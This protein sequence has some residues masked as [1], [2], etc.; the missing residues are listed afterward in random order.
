MI[1]RPYEIFNEVTDVYNEESYLYDFVIG[2]K[3]E[4]EHEYYE[5]CKL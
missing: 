5:Q 2:V 3:E 4:Q 1:I